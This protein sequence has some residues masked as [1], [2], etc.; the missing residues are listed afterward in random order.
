MFADQF[1]EL[2]TRLPSTYAYGLGEHSHNSFRHTFNHK[3]WGMFA[4]DQP[5]GGPQNLYGVHPYIQ[6]VE[7]D[8]GNAYGLLFLNANAQGLH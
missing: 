4:R 3:S 8:E 1:R 6:V 2:T 7:N 5:P